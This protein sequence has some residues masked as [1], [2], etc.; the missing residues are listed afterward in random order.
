M[1]PIEPVCPIDRFRIPR[2]QLLLLGGESRMRFTN[3]KDP[4]HVVS[5]WRD[6]RLGVNP[7]VRRV[8]Y[9]YSTDGGTSWALSSLLPS[10]DKTYSL[11]SDP[12]MCVDTSGKFYLATISIDNKGLDGIVTVC[13][14]TNNGATFDKGVD[15]S[16]H[17]RGKYFDD[18][19][20]MTC[21]FSSS[22][23][24]KNTIYISWTRYNQ[25]DSSAKV[26][27]VKSSDEGKS[28]SNPSIVIDPK[29]PDFATGSMP[30]TGPNGDVYVVY[31][32]NIK[33]V[34]GLYISKSTNGGNNF[35]SYILID[36]ASF[37]GLPSI[38][39]DITRGAKNG[40]LYAVWAPFN[41]SKQEILFTYSSDAGKSWSKCKTVNNEKTAD[42]QYHTQ[43]SMTVDETGKIFIIYYS[44]TEDKTI[45]EVYLATSVNGGE[46]FTNELL[47]SKLPPSGSRNFGH[48]IGIDAL[49]NKIMPVWTDNRAGVD[50]SEIYTAYKNKTLAGES[51]SVTQINKPPQ[52]Y[53]NFPLVE[54]TTSGYKFDVPKIL[55]TRF[56]LYD[57]LGRKSEILVKEMTK[58]RYYEEVNHILTPSSYAYFVKLTGLEFK[59]FNKWMLKTMERLS[60]KITELKNRANGS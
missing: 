39:A 12:V 42:V 50:N 1:D 15:V 16:P 55:Y 26:L 40:Y 2:D 33:D 6:F 53:E 9:S 28:W 22:S 4:N 3:R 57:N 24:Y 25:R 58:K 54:S 38:A 27:L 17:K 8:G 56:N 47:S 44:S 21:D 35:S 45:N 29:L 10:F 11:A 51:I 19:E 36:T 18:K 37:P 13:R 14:S 23:P 59:K 46:S 49:S 5:A 32:G 20:F 34:Y 43:P 60:W 30:V 41:E 52:I 31:A 48:Y 7:P